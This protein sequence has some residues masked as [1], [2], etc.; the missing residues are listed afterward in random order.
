MKQRFGEK[1]DVQIYTMASEEARDYLQ[2]FMGATN[3]FLDKV[4]LP[5]PVVIDREKMEEFLTQKL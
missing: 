2:D 3:V 4:R 1:L 5:L